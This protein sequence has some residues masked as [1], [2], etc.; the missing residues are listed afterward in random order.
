[1]HLR[2]AIE[3]AGRLDL[4]APG[5]RAGRARELVARILAGPE[6]WTPVGSSAEDR[7]AADALF[8]A[9]LVDLF[10]G[11]GG[12]TLATLTPA[13]ADRLGVRPEETIYLRRHS[14]RIVVNGRQ[15]AALRGDVMRA[16]EC[17]EISELIVDPDSRDTLAIIDT[18]E[19][20]AVLEEREA[21]EVGYPMPRSRGFAPLP[22]PELVP[23]VA[24]DPEP[25]PEPAP[26]PGPAPAVAWSLWGVPVAP[27]RRRP[28]SSKPARPRRS[29]A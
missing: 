8:G 14:A 22:F 11:P 5:R 1:M 17:G 26:E 13:L 20:I 28:R 7:G 4:A 24:P 15:V 19:S 3:M 12:E 9:G 2:D 21:H 23:E 18:W 6:L 29:V 25:A 16:L 10:D 27:L